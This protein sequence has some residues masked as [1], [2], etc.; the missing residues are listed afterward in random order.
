M[1]IVNT[2]V[3]YEMLGK[4]KEPN[5]AHDTDSGFDLYSPEECVLLPGELKTIDLKIRFHIPK[6]VGWLCEGQ[7][8]PKSGRSKNGL[9]VSLGTADQSYRGSVS[10][11]IHNRT[12][13][14]VVIKENEKLCQIVW[15]LIP[16][17]EM[18]KGIVS[19]DT[20]RGIGGFGSTGL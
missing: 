1:E 7:I 2:K 18:E 20:E 16:I 11:T 3:I 12:K 19:T 8:R 15:V 5:R 17:M 6:I 9:E 14:T 4:Q 10:A 13:E